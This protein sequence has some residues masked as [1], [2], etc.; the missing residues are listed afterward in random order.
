MLGTP[1]YLPPET[2][3]HKGHNK[4]AD[5]WAF[6]VLAYELLTG[7]VPFDNEVLDELIQAVS[8]GDVQYPAEMP[9]DAVDFIKQ[10]LNI[11]RDKRLGSN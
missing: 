3:T 11:D 2:L 7:V 6:G 4:A 8:K 1:E 9:E 5:W 10:L